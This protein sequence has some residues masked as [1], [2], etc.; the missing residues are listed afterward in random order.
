MDAAIWFF[1]AVSACFLLWD[2]FVPFVPSDDWRRLD[3]VSWDER[4]GHRLVT[5]T[6]IAIIVVIVEV[7]Q[8]IAWRIAPYV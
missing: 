6:A 2:A 7:I 4:R 3:K 5:G 8:G 1:I